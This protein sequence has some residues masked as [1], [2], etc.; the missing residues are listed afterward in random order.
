MTTNQI[1]KAELAGWA[2]VFCTF[3]YE[4]HKV[5]PKTLNWSNIERKYFEK[6]QNPEIAAKS[7][8]KT[9]EEESLVK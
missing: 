1:T 5:E 8:L 7:Y 3:L 9:L 2:C 4:K 6:G